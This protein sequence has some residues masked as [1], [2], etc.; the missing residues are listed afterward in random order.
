VPSVF[1][2]EGPRLFGARVVHSTRVLASAPPAAVNPLDVVA[3][4]AT[5]NAGPSAPA[6]G[7]RMGQLADWLWANRVAAVAAAVAATS[8]G[9]FLQCQ[10]GDDHGAGAMPALSGSR[11]R[12]RTSR[13][14]KGRR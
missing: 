11:R 8:L 5:S 7:D 10:L 6:R 9:L 12:C 14:R 2:L 4:S 1:T 3:A 13:C